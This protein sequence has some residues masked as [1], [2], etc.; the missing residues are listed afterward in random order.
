MKA[1]RLVINIFC[2][3][4]AIF[5]I[6]PVHA[7][8]EIAYPAF[9]LT[10]WPAEI[11]N[12]FYKNI[13]EIQ[14]KKFTEY[15]L[16]DILKKIAA[17]YPIDNLKII[18]KNNNLYLLGT[19]N[20]KIIAINYNM[21]G[22]LNSED[23]K[24]LVGLS[25]EDSQN[26]AKIV[27]AEDKIRTY[28]KNLGYRNIK[29]STS[30]QTV[31]NLA[32]V[33]NFNIEPGAKTIISGIVISGF[34]SATENKKFEDLIYWSGV[35]SVLSDDKIKAITQKLRVQ[36]SQS[37]YYLVA[38]G[39]PQITFNQ[40]DTEGRLIYKL[41][42]KPQYAVEILGAKNYSSL[43]LMT[44]VLAMN[45]YFSTEN[46]F[47]AELSEKLRSFYLDKGF[48]Q[49][50]ITYYERIE[51]KKI[52]LSLVIN[53]GRKTLIENIHFNGQISRPENFYLQHYL[54]LASQKIQDH[55]WVKT[56]SDQAGKNLITSLQ[57]EGFVSAKLNRIETLPSKTNPDHVNVNVRLDE[58][59]PV[60]IES[61]RFEN[62]ETYSDSVLLKKMGLSIGQKLNLNEL[63]KALLQLKLFYTE[64]GFIEAQIL[65]VKNNLITYNAEST[66]AQIL[67]ELNEGVPITVGSIVLDGNQLTHGKL[68]L[69]ELEFRPGD[70]L[71]PQKIDE[72]IS[73]LQK[74]GHF[75][76]INIYSLE[77]NSKLKER[78][79]VVKVSERKPI[80]LTFGIGAT[81][82]NER[83]FHTYGGL[84]HRNFGGWGRGLSGRGE[85][86]Y[87]DVFLKFLEQK[88][89]LGYLEPYLFDT[90]MR[91]RINYTTQVNVSDINLRKQT[92]ANS[93]VWAVE[94]DFTSHITGIWDIYNITN[95]V[96][97]GINPEDE[98]KYKYTG[99]DF[100][101]ALT[102]PTVD[103]DYRDQILNPQKGHFTR[104]SL[105]YA[106]ESLGNHK[107]DDFIRSTAQSTVYFPLMRDQIIWAN[108]VR[109]GYVTPVGAT[110]YGIPYD[111]KGFILGGRST[112][113]GF[114]SIEFFPTSDSANSESLGANY[115][116][117]APASFQLIKSEFR[118]PLF[119]KQDI[120]A[121]IFYDGGQVLI[122]NVK[123]SDPYRDVI[124]IGFRY[125]TPVGPLN[126]EY[127]HKLDRKPS[128]SEGAFHLS[129][130]VF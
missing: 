69:T 120:S 58:G 43:Y 75:T 126:L 49:F 66:A 68:I 94:Q 1:D 100:A 115:K 18:L 74:T 86:N 98:I 90:R 34:E 22:N 103:I 51:N 79:I 96:E 61:I 3:I 108:S 118:F 62:N 10:E 67:I 101:I 104:L 29:I 5:I 54:D 92:I 127:A 95:Y 15:E 123:F 87:N 82:E 93:A 6:Q 12:S 64:N 23:F 59:Q 97:K 19:K 25:L 42:G 21:T 33:L 60:V 70:L 44:D 28:L 24:S 30:Y 119:P 106:S 53:E 7:D 122:D 80:L 105:E 26:K 46:N 102:G 31:E 129:V 109:G 8:V 113:R 125:S 77:P 107:V 124:G 4:A 50:Q 20:S 35:G 41:K 85:L 84:A 111:K 27:Q 48:S 91:F 40:D 17:G 9:D 57:N 32:R 16:N 13:P 2:F 76:S 99:Q 117:T 52:I 38:T 37:G 112:I 78:T 65:N 114:E 89:T 81:N 45:S 39:S 121:A 130:G 73:R 116:F 11:V 36:L 83:T 110:L 63:E 72:S 47:G 14:N 88:I 55:V 56:E 128:E 71:T